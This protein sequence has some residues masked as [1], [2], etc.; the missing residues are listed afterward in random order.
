MR[1][2][3]PECIF[4]LGMN[5]LVKFILGGE[6][7][8]TVRSPITYTYQLMLMILVTFIELFPYVRHHTECSVCIGDM[9][10]N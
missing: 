8:K 3:N 7:S 2:L 4:W 9:P 1:V 5:M 10:V 6:K